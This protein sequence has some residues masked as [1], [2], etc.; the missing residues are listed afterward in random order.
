MRHDGANEFGKSKG[1]RAEAV[2]KR[3]KTTQL[4]ASTI[5][6][7]LLLG[8]SLA[9]RMMA[10]GIRTPPKQAEQM[11]AI[12]QAAMTNKKLL[13]NARRPQMRP[14]RTLVPKRAINQ[15]A[16]LNGDFEELTI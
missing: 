3:V 11:P 12:S 2:V 13:P 6:C 8:T 9:K 16:T 14:K 10:S 1:G 4:G 5:E 15:I 7:G